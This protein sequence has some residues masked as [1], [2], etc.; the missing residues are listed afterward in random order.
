MLYLRK[1]K[2]AFRSG[3]KE[4]LKAVQRELRKKIREGKNSHRR[5]MAN[6]LQQSNVSGVC[7]SLKTISG[8]R[9]PDSQAVGDQ[10][11]WTAWTYSSTGLTSHPPLPPSPLPSPPFNAS[12]S[13]ST[14][15][16]L[17]TPPHFTPDEDPGV[18]DPRPSP[19][20]GGSFYGPTP[21]RL[22]T[23]YCGQCHHIPPGQITVSPGQAWE[24]CE[25]H[26]LWFLHCF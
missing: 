1:K 14:A 21:V 24:Q 12:T 4:E 8:Q 23:W 20:S 3:N 19:P 11:G 16:M 2:K 15:F 13:L 26:V 25:D 6:Q 9:K 17:Q 10:I 18:A 7:N 5:K 22:S